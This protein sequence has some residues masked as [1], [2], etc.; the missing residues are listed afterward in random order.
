M[1]LKDSEIMRIA[2]FIRLMP[3]HRGVGGMQG[4]A[5]TLYS[6]L[7]ERGHDV[8]VYTTAHSDCEVERHPSGM[9]IYYIKGTRP[10]QVRYSLSYT[11]MMIYP[12]YAQM[13]SPHGSERWLILVEL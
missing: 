10:A 6:G 7:A 11:L 5:L 9:I 2:G 13:I 12:N 4:H 8:H 3:K 1:Y